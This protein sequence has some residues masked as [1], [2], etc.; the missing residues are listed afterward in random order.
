[1]HRFVPR[2]VQ[3]L[4]KQA[5]RLK[6]LLDCSHSH[7]LDKVAQQNGYTNWS[8][9]QKHAAEKDSRKDPARV[10]GVSTTPGG[11][12]VI[13]VAAIRYAPDLYMDR[14]DPGQLIFRCPE[15]GDVHY[16]GAVDWYLGAGDGD[17]IPHCLNQ[18]AKYHFDLVEVLE[19]AFAGF[20]PQRILKH[21]A[22][23]TADDHIKNWFVSRHT[24]AVDRSPWNGR[25]GGYVY[26]TY[27]GADDIHV[28]LC[29]AFP[30]LD[31]D[32]LFEIAEE[33]DEGGPWITDAFLRIL[34]DEAMAEL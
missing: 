19:P 9:L 29:E 20:L 25:E 22:P 7:A 23:P 15:C 13:R 33:L 32:R 16:H 27:E 10:L 11:M 34:D 28:V 2:E 8:L 30:S 12:R 6:Q 3:A 31:E 18:D 17:R 1:M 24:P 4:K 26:P 5:K 21:F 14:H